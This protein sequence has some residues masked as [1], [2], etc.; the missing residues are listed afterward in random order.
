MTPSL[1]CCCCCFVLHHL[2]NRERQREHL[3]SSGCK[4]QSWSRVMDLAGAATAAPKILSRKK[5]AQLDSRS[6]CWHLWTAPHPLPFPP[7]HPRLLQH[8]PLLGVGSLWSKRS[9]NGKSLQQCWRS[10]ASAHSDRL[11]STIKLGKTNP[12]LRKFIQWHRS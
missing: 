9:R 6:Q 1:S 3:L 5:K 12:K 10:W 8:L 4:S 7:P 2:N 11:M